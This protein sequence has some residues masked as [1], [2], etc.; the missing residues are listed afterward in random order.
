MAECK[1]LERTT[2]AATFWKFYT[3]TY[4]AARF[5][6]ELSVC[7]GKKYFYEI[8]GGAKM[9]SALDRKNM[10]ILRREGKLRPL[11]HELAHVYLDIRWQVLPY[12]VAEPLVAAMEI[13]EK[14]ELAGFKPVPKEIL[15]QRWQD[16]ENLDRCGKVKLIRD[17]LNSEADIRLGLLVR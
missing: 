11:M 8:K 15:T 9:T 13:T 1:P 5:P 12:P 4:G 10:R 7:T 2:G 14:C 16:R 3:D 17:V 6:A